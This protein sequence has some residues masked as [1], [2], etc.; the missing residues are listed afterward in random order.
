MATPE[1]PSRPRVAPRV[2]A[3]LVGL[4]ALAASAPA[5]A[6]A[7][8]F[9]PRGSSARVERHHVTVALTASG[10][11]TWSTIDLSGAADVGVIVAVK[12]GGRVEL[13]GRTWI[14]VVE[15]ATRVVVTAIPADKCKPIAVS[16]NV[17]LDA[18]LDLSGEGTGGCNGG[19]SAKGN[20]QSG[21][22]WSNSSAEGSGCSP[23]P[24]DEG[25]PGC[26]AFN[27]TTG[28]SPVDPGGS[29][30]LDASPGPPRV[31]P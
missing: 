16:G 18:G 31:G 5:A 29:S 13:A 25:H 8:A 9:V 19:G 1:K 15:E 14:D 21:G 7:A 4:G 6:S 3:A 17:S 22:C 20:G 23:T 10:T 26:S 11:I 28:C 24:S 27:T 12:A 2:L 30:P